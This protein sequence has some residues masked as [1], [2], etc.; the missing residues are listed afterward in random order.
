MH[1]RRLSQLAV[2]GV[3]LAAAIAFATPASASVRYD[4]GRKT[5]FVD[6][7]DVQK[8]FGWTDAVLAA[9]ASHLVFDHDFWTDDSYSVTCGR[10]VFP[11][12]HHRE[13]GHFELTD[14]VIHDRRRGSTV[15]YHGK[16]V[17]FRLTGARSGIS[18]TSVPPMVGQPCPDGQV[19]G[20]AIDKVRLTS[21]I[22]GWA[23]TISSHDVRR[24]ILVN[25]TP[26][27]RT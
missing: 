27:P 13:Y 6:R 9:R 21:S 23:L 16:L 19:P 11:V 24:Q 4:P 15:G 22:T 12:V 2:A 26:N 25:E 14:A 17:G 8:A 1:T 20:S 5:G 10:R 3:T 7:S 18:G